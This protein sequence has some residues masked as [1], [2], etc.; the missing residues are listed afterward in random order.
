MSTSR[1]HSGEDPYAANASWLFLGA[2]G[3]A[4]TSTLVRYSRRHG[5]LYAAEVCPEFHAGIPV[6]AVCGDH[7]SDLRQAQRL[8]QDAALRPR[9][10]GL[11]IVAGESRPGR[12]VESSISMLRGVFASV[13]RVP[14]LPVLHLVEPA[15]ATEQPW[16]AIHPDLQQVLDDIRAAA[17]VQVTPE[18][19]S[20]FP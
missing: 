9:L 16:P 19:E 2:H 4:G 10:L 1:H 5:H 3:G 17:A 20:R 7:V 15:E 12:A 8:S 6:V 18:N 11:A 13:W 14:H